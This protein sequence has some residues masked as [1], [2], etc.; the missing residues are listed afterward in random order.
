MMRGSPGDGPCRRQVATRAP[1]GAAAG[2]TSGVSLTTPAWQAVLQAVATWP[3]CCQLVVLGKLGYSCTIVPN[4]L[5]QL[6]TAWQLGSYQQYT[7][8]SLQL[9]YREANY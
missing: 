5:A 2:G 6:A 4:S 3:K 7:T 9:H 8:T 1:P